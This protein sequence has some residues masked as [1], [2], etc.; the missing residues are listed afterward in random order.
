MRPDHHWQDNP[1]MPFRVTGEETVFKG[2]VM[3]VAVAQ[4]EGPDGEQ[5]Q[6]D[7]LHHPG[8][9]AVV[10]LHDDGSVTL[11][12]QYRVALGR[13]LW[14]IP[15]GLRDVDGEP[16]VETAQRELIEEAGLE[17]A[18]LDHLAMFHNSPGHSDEIVHI[19][20]GTGLADV[21]DDRQGTEEQ[22]MLVARLPLELALQMI[23][24][25]RIT[26][27]K[28]VIGLLRAA[29]TPVADGGE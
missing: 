28:T 11:V 10:P 16:P 23:D 21:D 3:H 13:G 7:V 22:H 2:R 4:V 5:H 20:L 24:D 6:R 12:N 9:V 29:A 19:Y 15:A 17:A 18:R 27:A 8:A 14:E 26:D 1:E 25:G